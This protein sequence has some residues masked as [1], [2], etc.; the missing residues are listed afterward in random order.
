MQQTYFS[1]N[2]FLLLRFYSWYACV[3]VNLPQ[4]CPT[5]DDPMDCSPSGSSVHRILQARILEWVATPS[6]GDLPNSG[7]E[8]S[9]SS[10]QVD[11]LPTE[12]P[13]KP[14]YDVL[15]SVIPKVNYFYLLA[16]ILT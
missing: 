2:L 9:S 10:S 1:N 16:I 13:G 5:L 4:S 8:H 7:I 11:S 12:F 15:R 14:W 6:P 3:C